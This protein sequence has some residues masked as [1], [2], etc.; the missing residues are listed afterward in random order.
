M[1]VKILELIHFPELLTSKN[2]S[3]NFSNVIDSPQK[4]EKIL[5]VQ[6]P[7]H[8]F[9]KQSKIT[10]VLAASELIDD[11]NENFVRVISSPE[12]EVLETTSPTLKLSDVHESLPL[13]QRL[14]NINLPKNFNKI[15][16]SDLKQP[17]SIEKLS[18]IDFSYIESL[19]ISTKESSSISALQILNKKIKA[20]LKRK[21]K[22]LGRNITFNS[23]KSFT[24]IKKVVNSINLRE[25]N[26]SA[27][28]ASFDTT[29]VVQN[30]N[31]NEVNDLD[32]LQTVS[33]DI[34]FDFAD[35]VCDNLDFKAEDETLLHRI[36][37]AHDE[38]KQS[39]LLNDQR[40]E[41]MNK[42][43][44]N[45]VELKN[46]SNLRHNQNI[47]YSYNFPITT[48][49]QEYCES[50]TVIK[51]DSFKRDKSSNKNNSEIYNISNSL[52]I[53]SDVSE[54]KNI[55]KGSNVLD[56][57][58]CM[59]KHNL[60]SSEHRNVS[61]SAHSKFND[62]TFNR[63]SDTFEQCHFKY[64]ACEKNVL[65]S[66]KTDANNDLYALNSSARE[67]YENENLKLQN[68]SE[69]N[70]DFNIDFADNDVFDH[71]SDN[72]MEMGG[73]GKIYNNTSN[74]CNISTKVSENIPIQNKNY[75]VI[76]DNFNEN[77]AKDLS[78]SENRNDSVCY[79]T[80]DKVNK[81]NKLLAEEHENSTDDC[82]ISFD[83]SFSFDDNQ[84]KIDSVNVSKLQSITNETTVEYSVTK[85]MHPISNLEQFN[86]DAN[87]IVE[88]LFTSQN[89]FSAKLDSSFSLPLTVKRCISETEPQENEINCKKRIKTSGSGLLKTPPRNTKFES[90]NV[91]KIPAVN[92]NLSLTKNKYF[93]K[94]NLNKSLNFTQESQYGMTQL[95]ALIDSSE[96]LD[97]NTT[98][99]SF[100]VT[101]KS[102]H[103]CSEVVDVSSEDEICP[104]PPKEIA[105]AKA[106][107]IYSS[108]NTIKKSLSFE[109]FET[110]KQS[111]LQKSTSRIQNDLN[112]SFPCG[113]SKLLKNLSETNTKLEVANNKKNINNAPSLGKKIASFNNM[114]EEG[115][116]ND[117]INSEIIESQPSQKITFDVSFDLPFTQE[118]S[119]PLESQ[120]F[121]LNKAICEES[122]SDVEIGKGSNN[123]SIK[124]SEGSES[125]PANNLGK[126]TISENVKGINMTGKS[127]I[128]E[129]YKTDEL[130]CEDSESL[131][132]SKPLERNILN[133]PDISYDPLSTKHSTIFS[134]KNYQNTSTTHIEA[135]NQQKINEA[136]QSCKNSPIEKNVELNS[137]LMDKFEQNIF[138]NNISFDLMQLED[139]KVSKNNCLL[140]S[141][142]ISNSAHDF[143]KLDVHYKFTKSIHDLSFEENSELFGNVTSDIFCKDQPLV[144]KEEKYDNI[145]YL[146][147]SE[148]QNYNPASFKNELER[149]KDLSLLKTK[150]LQSK[151]NPNNS[152]IFSEEKL[153]FDLCGDNDE[154]CDLLPL[155]SDSNMQNTV[156]SKKSICTSKNVEGLP[157]I[158]FT[159]DLQ[160][161][162]ELNKATKHFALK[163]NKVSIKQ[164]NK[165]YSEERVDDVDEDGGFTCEFDLSE[166]EQK[167]LQEIEEKSISHQHNNP[168]SCKDA[169]D[170]VDS[171]D[172]F[173][174]PCQSILKHKILNQKC[175]KYVANKPATNFSIIC[176]KSD[177]IS[178]H[179]LNVKDQSDTS[180]IKFNKLSSNLKN[181]TKWVESNV[182]KNN[183]CIE[184]DEDD[185]QFVTKIPKKSGE[186]SATKERIQEKNTSKKR[187]KTARHKFLLSQADVSGSDNSD[188]ESTCDDD[189]KK[190]GMLESF[191][192]DNSPPIHDVTD[193]HAI[194]LQSVKNCDGLPQKFKLKVSENRNH[195]FSIEPPGEYSNYMLDSFCVS[196]EDIA[197]I[198][199]E[200]DI[201]CN[202]KS[203]HKSK[204]T[205]K[206][207]KKLKR[208]ITHDSTTSSESEISPQRK[209]GREVTFSI[210]LP[211]SVHDDSVIAPKKHKPKLIIISSDEDNDVFIKPADVKSHGN[212]IDKN[213]CQVNHTNS[214]NNSVV[215]LADVTETMGHTEKIEFSLNFDE[216]NDDSSPVT[217]NRK[218]EPVNSGTLIN[219]TD[220]KELYSS[221]N[222][223]CNKPSTSKPEDYDSNSKQSECNM[224]DDLDVRDVSFDIGWDDIDFPLISDEIDSVSKNSTFVSK[225]PDVRK[226]E[227]SFSTVILVDSR[228]LASGKPV[229]SALR[230]KY[231]VNPIVMQLNSAD[232]VISNR[233]AIERVSDSE[234][235]NT[236]MPPKIIEKI[237]LMNETY[238]RSVVIIEKDNRKRILSFNKNTTKYLQFV[239]HLNYC[240]S[241]T[242]LFSK[243]IEST[244]ELIS[245]L[246]LQEKKKGYHINVP[247]SL[248][249][250]NQK[251]Y[252]FYLSFP[253]VSPVCAFYLMYYFPTLKSFS[254][255]SVEDLKKKCCIPSHKALSLYRYFR[256]EI[257]FHENS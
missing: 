36:S 24:P 138:E 21:S 31:H 22:E 154:T 48:K 249:P 169:N 7:S 101:H 242:V 203:R 206:P 219:A 62:S 39:L 204:K 120:S 248:N 83:V 183:S 84:E 40:N 240:P 155:E 231:N 52:N 56:S 127:F 59:N 41:S 86:E 26:P 129:N 108:K 252:D 105:K 238:D 100:S 166:A 209:V 123:S 57:Q 153:L 65:N 71:I 137:S 171:N 20:K 158:N 184:E 229:I 23:T 111:N 113:Q 67:L 173:D 199:S 202:K 11:L 89:K 119:S 103:Q 144:C 216:Y 98:R 178:K 179:N 165:K 215:P 254:K 150:T 112:S 37:D 182:L 247:V 239:V 146:K 172:D 106:K 82:N 211:T 81:H 214:K 228:E 174:D 149:E 226:S 43:N 51:S 38:N 136:A 197:Y 69:I 142:H 180:K 70:L 168:V 12:K 190:D 68:S 102:P 104:T 188:D 181:K 58:V 1:L 61:H 256:N 32:E 255:S 213:K 235:T 131:L 162:E 194:Y 25:G 27:F 5:K 159:S 196:D 29:M 251:L 157:L 163:N 60:Q 109:S 96:S 107:F 250:K 74:S 47:P 160:K 189:E 225:T 217:V 92:K 93:T 230:S 145:P 244:S 76:S 205:K 46:P 130:D 164:I 117:N 88:Q 114:M 245:D 152:G 78:K 191:I 90:L 207:S 126:E 91:F 208:V 77:S 44:E 234:F 49:V 19:N 15:S 17:P 9:F 143:E 28:D 233:L 2:S 192:D 3:F 30:E 223:V 201:E 243:S 45:S 222:V 13:I 10:D 99:K 8:S 116:N 212:Q 227:E 95:L 118:F 141:K 237:K 195:S 110:H 33:F 133:S 147:A 115:I 221:G 257:T 64:P 187:K 246:I 253:E 236:S 220:D 73:K 148:S 80:S 134:D 128:K 72:V 75:P 124:L 156:N 241:T 132:P 139:A 210:N 200:N 161:S 63:K 176:G 14:F 50:E 177:S 35:P 170:E 34:D 121:D 186:S 18:N 224:V 53:S 55:V 85:N 198:S 232:Y 97:K 79:N 94:N 87:S 16:P 185:F 4:N 135:L 42:L 122:F 54:E 125:K 193:Q 175:S 6:D 140:N 66:S 167:L 218:T 151:P